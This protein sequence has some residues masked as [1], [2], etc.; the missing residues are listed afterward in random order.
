VGYLARSFRS[1]YRDNILGT[2]RHDQFWILLTFMPTFMIAR[3]LVHADP[4]LFLNV[5]GTHIHH[6]AYGIFLVALAGYLSLIDRG[7]SRSII[8][9]IYGVG[10][11]LAFDEFGMWIHLTD[12]YYLRNSYDAVLL[13][14]AFLLGTIYFSDVIRRSGRLLLWPLRKR[15]R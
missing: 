12:D 11:A 3:L 13:I 8:A 4:N 7:P 15:R 6:F 10:L 5:H 9:A 14:G 1:L 2:S